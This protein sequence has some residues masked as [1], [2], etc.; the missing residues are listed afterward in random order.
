MT[1]RVIFVIDWLAPIQRFAGVPS[2]PFTFNR[3]LDGSLEEV[4]LGRLEIF[5]THNRRGD[6]DKKVG[7]LT[8]LGV[9]AEGVAEQGKVAKNGDLGIA[10]ANVILNEAAKDQ[11]VATGNHDVGVNL[12][13]VIFVGFINRAGH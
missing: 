8:R 2:G 11:R 5:V 3:I 12:A 6:K 13:N 10:G 4:T 9:A 1:K 7:F